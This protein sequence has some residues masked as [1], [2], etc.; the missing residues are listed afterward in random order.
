MKQTISK[1]LKKIFTKPETLFD[2]GFLHDLEAVK[3]R[4][5]VANIKRSHHTY[6]VLAAIL[7]GVMAAYGAILFRY[8]IQ[9]S[10]FS[11]YQS[12]ELSSSWLL[13]LPWYQR[14]LIP[15]FGGL[16][17][18]FIVYKVSP[19]V[20]GSG[21]PE[22]MESVA[23]KGGIIRFRVLFT[24][25]VAAAIT[26][27]SG[28][29]AGREG[30][31]VH[32]GSAIGA[33]VGQVFKLSSKH[34]RT[35]V[36]CGAAAGIAA[37][38]NA[39]IAGALFAMEVILVDMSVISMS[40]I[41]IASVIATVISRHYLGDFPAFEVPGFEFKNAFELI[42][43]SVLGLLSALVATS[44]IA[45]F[46][47]TST[48]FDSMTIPLWI[49]PALGGLGVGVI[50]IFIPQVFG[51]GY[52]TINEA[53]W[54]K[55]APLFMLTVLFSKMIATSLSLGSGGSGGIFAPS[56]VIGSTLGA[57]VGSVS[58]SL[59][60]EITAT[61]GA[62]ALVGMGA[63]VS[64]VTHA[65]I[66]A[67]L[68]IFELTNDYQTIPP[69]MLSC[70]IAVL[71]S[72]WISKDSIYTVKLSSRGIKLYEGKDVN[73]LKEIKV[74]EVMVKD[75]DV[76]CADTSFSEL[77]HLL[78]EG[79]QPYAIVVDKQKRYVGTISLN[80]IKE[81]LPEADMLGEMVRAIDVTNEQTP[82]VLPDDS[83]DL[84]MHFFG[85]HH[86]TDLVVCDSPEKKGVIGLITRSAVITTY[87]KR[88]FNEDLTGGFSSIMSRVGH[89]RLIE[90]LGGIHMGEIDIPTSW[91]GRSI[92]QINLRQKH[93]LEIVLI[94][95]SQFSLE[96]L[97]G[98]PGVFPSPDLVLEPG[99]KLLVM[100][101]I[102]NLNQFRR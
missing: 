102:K 55:A 87:N 92:R 51:V 24:K 81:V 34:M 1:L 71:L 16:V 33:A 42:P 12:M 18:G 30:P 43:Y 5:F 95:R 69:L 40:P 84:V 85:K 23:L 60:P 56:L 41:V 77:L 29:S 74:R 76:V 58:Q 2:R 97:E 13:S 100:G 63:M 53:L 17:V 72:S 80:D 39:P 54:S 94:H 9:I 10:H 45:L 37:T 19:E 66:A 57:M 38:F 4:E 27:G 59:F 47:K 64:G 11:F 61:P 22:V 90:I 73:L 7:I 68:I 32:I 70:V 93:G 3:M 44:F 6:R 49:R 21:I 88:I 78:L 75:P 8:L 25:A 79:D 62:Y 91:I 48:T 98:R 35:F 31:I 99:D 20:K 67:I 96:G 50:G 82:F 52:E 46:K 65:P 101:D 86:E 26:I 89:G 15:A 28:G 83:L 14:L 36:A